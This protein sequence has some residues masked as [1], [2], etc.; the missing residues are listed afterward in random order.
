MPVCKGPGDTIIGGSLNQQGVLYSEATHV[1]SNSMLAQIVKLVEDAQTSKA[2][3]Q[4]LA[5]RIAGYFVPGIVILALITF[6]CWTVIVL[7][8]K[9]KAS[10]K[11][12]LS[13]KHAT[14]SSLLP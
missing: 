6:A 9:Y 13:P 8:D 3:I 4:L 11:F 14:L 2:P 12:K 10:L 7:E 5:D 1:G